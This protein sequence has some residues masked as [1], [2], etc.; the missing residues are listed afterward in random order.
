[1]LMERAVKGKKGSTGGSRPKLDGESQAQI[2]RML[3][4]M[5]DEVAQEPVPEK[6]LDLLKQLER[7][8][9]SKG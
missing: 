2:G 8:E 4:A 1:M 9:P 6:F 7:K 3:K 5:Y